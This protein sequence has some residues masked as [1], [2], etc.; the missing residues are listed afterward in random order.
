MALFDYLEG[1]YMRYDFLF[2]VFLFL[3]LI[4]YT[5]IHSENID[6][7]IS[8]SA[9]E[10]KIIE[11]KVDSY[12]F[13]PDHIIVKVN[14]PVE[15]KLRSVTSIISHNFTINYPEAGLEIDQHISSGDDESLTFTPTKT[16]KYEFY[17][18]KKNIFANH[19]KKGMVGILEVVK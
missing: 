7:S 8:A 11:I 2:K 14:Q 3:L 15:L 9:A 4:S 5:E 18:D 1:N 19:R 10:V 17:C 12:S 6:Q 13:Q 16:G